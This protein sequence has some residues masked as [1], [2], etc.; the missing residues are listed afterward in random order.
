MHHGDPQRVATVWRGR[1]LV[2]LLAAAGAAVVLVGCGGSPRGRVGG[3]GRTGVGARAAGPTGPP[4]IPASAS[5]VPG[6]WTTDAQLRGVACPAVATCVAVGQSASDQGA[7]LRSLDGGA[8]W[9]TAAGPPAAGQLASVACPTI[10]TCVAVGVSTTFHLAVYVSDDDGVQWSAAA[11]PPVLAPLAAVACASSAVCVAVGG[12]VGSQASAPVVLHSSNGGRAWTSGVL[13]PG[14]DELSA[15]ACPSATDCVAVGQSGTAAGTIDPAVVQSSDG[16]A[17]WVGRPVPVGGFVPSAIACSTPAHCVMAGYDENQ[18]VDVFLVSANGGATWA[19]G[20]NAGGAPPS[21]GSPAAVACTTATTC[22]AVTQ[23]AMGVATGAVSTTADG[24]HTWTTAGHLPSTVLPAAEACPTFDG[25]V[26][27]GDGGGLAWTTH[28]GGGSWVPSVTPTALGALAAV[29]C[30]TAEACVAVGQSSL[31]TPLALWTADGGRTWAVA[32]SPDV[33][34]GLDAVACPGRRVCVAVGGSQLGIGTA[35]VMRT[36]DGGRA[37]QTERLDEAGTLQAVACPTARLCVAGGTTF[38]LNVGEVPQITVASSDGGR[39]WRPMGAS[40]DTA[41]LAGLTCPTPRLC[42][43]VAGGLFASPTVLSLT[44]PGRVGARW[45]VRTRLPRSWRLTSIACPTASTCLAAGSQ[46]H[47][48]ASGFGDLVVGSHDA[49]RHWRVA[50]VY[51]PYARADAVGCVSATRCAV[52]GDGRHSQGAGAL[53]SV[54]GRFRPAVLP[55]GV[56]N[57]YGVTCVT[58]DRC[59]AVGT[60]PGTAAILA[61]DDAGADWHAQHLPGFVSLAA[62][63]QATS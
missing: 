3:H 4:A 15:A 7:V 19:P 25:C 40:P 6:A 52:V 10:S 45:V 43:A 5:P 11:V 36:T 17:T 1:R 54:A 21:G 8:T 53:V 26:V 20:S 22:L 34:G 35:L 57:L 9:T 12:A 28:D 38:S 29:R 32:P 56:G 2:P 14:I 51:P 58:S 63:P 37:W 27:V 33:T 47:A 49:G 60:V 31:R 62:P 44:D 41:A 59:L 16:G 48:G 61:S 50:T 18:R 24:G 30:W 13:P 55:G 46:E 42:L 39:T 23:P